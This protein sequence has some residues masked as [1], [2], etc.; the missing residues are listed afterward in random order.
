MDTSIK[1]RKDEDNIFFKDG[2][3]EEANK[4][5]TEAFPEYV[6]SEED[7]IAVLPYNGK[8]WCALTKEYTSVFLL[9]L[10]TTPNTN[11]MY[12]NQNDPNLGFLSPQS[13]IA[14]NIHPPPASPVLATPAVG[15]YSRLKPHSMLNTQIPNFLRCVTDVDVTHSVAYA[16]YPV[17]EKPINIHHAFKAMP[18]KNVFKGFLYWSDPASNDIPI[19]VDFTDLL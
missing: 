10:K 12:E 19:H 18:P 17:M 1:E 15:D 8:Y 14:L 16:S 7:T 11:Q 3:Y 6:F 4:L 2:K 5:Y 9:I 13:Q